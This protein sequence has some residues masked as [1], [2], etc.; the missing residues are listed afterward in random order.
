MSQ[1]PSDLTRA[2]TFSR[3]DFAKPYRLWTQAR[4]WGDYELAVES[5]FVPAIRSLFPTV[6]P[7]GGQ[8]VSPEVQLIPE[9]SG[10]RGPWAVSVR[11]DGRTIGYLA[12]D[13]TTAW[14][15]VLR[16]IVASGCI[17]TTACRIYGYE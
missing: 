4:S 1:P 13:D 6:W 17:P 8:E 10:L 11:A 14:A 7:G 9:P 5:E 16:R 12:D 15:G 2:E 3:C